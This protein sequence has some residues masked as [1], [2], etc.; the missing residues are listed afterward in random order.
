MLV[1]LERA[2]SPEDLGPCVCGLCEQEFVIETVIV[3]TIDGVEGSVGIICQE[4]L[5]YLGRR[6]PECPTIEQYH[7]L[8]EQYP[9]P[10]WTD[11]EEFHRYM[12]AASAEEQERVYREAELTARA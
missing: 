11:Q 9:E 4:C 2:I 7:E 8:V 1:R 10:M 6:Q 5:A 3:S 12:M